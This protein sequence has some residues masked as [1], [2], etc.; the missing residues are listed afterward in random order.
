MKLQFKTL[1]I[2]LLLPVLVF[3]NHD[4][5]NGKY[6]KEKTVKKE[7]T[8]NRDA[9][10]KIDNSYGNVD[11]I[12]WSE[13][14]TVIEVHIKTNSDNEEK[15]QKKLD[16]ITIEF[17]GSPSLVT[18]KTRF[19]KKKGSWSFWGKNDNVSM[20]INYTVKVPV[21]NSVDLSNDYG[22]ISLDKL[23]GHAKIDCDYGQLLIGDLRADNNSLSFDY[24]SKS[25]IAYMKSG[26]IDADYSGF[27]LEKTG[28]VE[29]NAD[30]TN[31]EIMDANNVSYSCDYG[32]V[33]IGSANNINGTGDYVTN[34]IGGVSGSLTLDTDYGSIKVDRLLGTAKDVTINA[35]YTGIK[36]GIDSGY[37]FDFAVDLS[38]SSLKGEDNVIVTKSHKE[39]SRKTYSGYHGTKGSGN[40][41]K[42]NSDYGGVTFIKN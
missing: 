11:V 24:T 30:Y 23:D 42:I 12:T 20:E 17:S 37:S 34:R 39:N 28:N 1:I 13:N 2:L 41:I 5:F 6:T 26:K 9:A 25:T 4:K 3:A 8:V 15:A 14:R 32:K 22:T 31:S 36:L 19:N 29:L 10:L 7:F 38:Y 33:V 16:D 40:T 18:A 21:T 27:V 35:D